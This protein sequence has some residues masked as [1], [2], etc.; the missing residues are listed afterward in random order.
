MLS[1]LAVALLAFGS[2]VHAF[3]S[4]AFFFELLLLIMVVY[5]IRRAH[6]QRLHKKWIESRFL[7]ER[8]R[9]AVFVAAC[10]EPATRYRHWR[11]VSRF[12]PWCC[13]QRARPSAGSAHREYSR[14]SKR[15]RN[16]ATGLRDIEQRLGNVRSPEA[17]K[18]FVRGSR[19]GWCARCRTG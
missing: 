8:L 7:A 2:L 13:L 11:A 9:H 16:M 4:F 19:P 5:I 15:S 17:L 1:V 14:L 6:S 3:A 12:W 10:G 18:A